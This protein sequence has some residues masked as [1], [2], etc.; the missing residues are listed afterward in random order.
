MTDTHILT[1]TETEP[2]KPDAF[3]ALCGYRSNVVKEFQPN[4]TRT[5]K[6]GNVKQ[7]VTCVKCIHLATQKRAE[8]V[9]AEARDN[10]WNWKG[11]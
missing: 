2:F 10:N 3:K 9:L 7:V 8:M 5:D 4:I 1:C 6:G 11:K